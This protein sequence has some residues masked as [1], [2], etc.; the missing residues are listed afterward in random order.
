[1]RCDS[2]VGGLIISLHIL[3]LITENSSENRIMFAL[4]FHFIVAKVS[5]YIFAYFSR[6]WIC[7][8]HRL[9]KSTEHLSLAKQTPM[10]HNETGTKAKAKAN[11]EKEENY[12]NV[13][14]CV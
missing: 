3:L 14:L 7:I 5:K 13:I 10:K 1:M 6:F 2:F 8:A 12:E 11:E 9:P 4:I